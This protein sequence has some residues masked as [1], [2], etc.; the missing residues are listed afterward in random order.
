LVFVEYGWR[1]QAGNI[2]IRPLNEEYLMGTIRTFIDKI[3]SPSSD[4]EHGAEPV[5]AAV[6]FH[7]Y[8]PSLRLVTY[9]W[10]GWYLEESV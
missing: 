10:S 3:V 1:A 4:P 9:P 2:P 8:G 7:P 5:L 6:T